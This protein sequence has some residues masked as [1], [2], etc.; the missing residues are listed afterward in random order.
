MSKKIL[1]V[2]LILVFIIALILIS[3]F[4]NNKNKDTQ[5]NKQ[6]NIMQENNI[7]KEESQMEVTKIGS[8]DFDKEVLQSDKTVLIDFYADWC[9]PCKSLSPIV[10]EVASENSEV[11]FVKINIDEN[12]DLARTYSVMSIP[13]LVVIKNG[14]EADR[15]VGLISKAKIENLIK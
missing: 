11:K 10:D 12:Q 13:T 8:E 2:I 7:N 6:S 1:Y 15:S 14:K 9:G 5:N 3:L 4:L